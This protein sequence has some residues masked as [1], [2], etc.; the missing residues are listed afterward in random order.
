MILGLDRIV[1]HLGEYVMG[2]LFDFYFPAQEKV[3]IPGPYISHKPDIIK[4]GKE[5]PLTVVSFIEGA[6]ASW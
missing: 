6:L 3:D 4:D 2:S 1:A 5:N